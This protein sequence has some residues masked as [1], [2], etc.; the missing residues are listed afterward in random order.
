MWRRCGKA[1]QLYVMQ[2]KTR[3]ILE[4]F[5]Y[6]SPQ[7]TDVLENLKIRFTQATAMNDPFESFPGILQKSKEWYRKKFP[8]RIREEA[9]RM[10]FRNSV[11]RKQYFKEREREFDT[12]YS[13]FSNEKWLVKQSQSIILKHSLVS[14]ELCLSATNKNI[15][16]WSH[17]AMDHTG[18]IIGF[19]S[20]HSFFNYGVRKV[21]YC[22]TRPYLDPTQSDQDAS[23]FYIKSLCWKY[24]EEYR[25]SID[26][27]K[28]IKQGDGNTFLP[29]PKSE[30]HPDDER[31]K[32]VHLIDF[33]KDSVTSIILGWKSKTD[34]KNKIALALES[35]GMSNVKIYKAEPHK[36]KYEMKICEFENA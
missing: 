29:F 2:C 23:I 36:C 18:Y 4:F 30:P 22:K 14:G 28:P 9:D 17:Y 27:V 24:E 3:R 26:L 34:L 13:T 31:L 25:K 10:Y 20:E 6:L 1:A 21:K 32:E 15:L 8:Q 12:F 7:R 5:K 19:D 35:H 16:M 33:P 11:E